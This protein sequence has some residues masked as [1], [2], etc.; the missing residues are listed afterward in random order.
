MVTGSKKAVS[1]DIQNRELLHSDAKKSASM[2]L[3]E[4]GCSVLTRLHADQR[5]IALKHYEL[6]AGKNPVL[7]AKKLREIIEDCAWLKAPETEVNFSINHT[8]KVLVPNA[9]YIP[10]KAREA[11]SFHTHFLPSDLVLTTD[12]PT[13]EAQLV[14]SVSH[15]LQEAIENELGRKVNIG[16]AFSTLLS[17]LVNAEKHSTESTLFAHIH[18]RY[19]D[20]IHLKK[21]KVHLANTFHIHSA[22]DYLYYL[23]FAMEQEGLNPET[24]KLVLLGDVYK[25]S[26]IYELSY[27]YVRHID[28]WKAKRLGNETFEFQELAAHLYFTTFRL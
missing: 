5:A 19:V 17:E 12:M 13:C 18:D 22:E 11:L 8:G 20:L 21:G 1:V 26:R 27:Q 15:Y 28:F 2:L 10:E 24:V 6:D 16:H 7:L 23:L 25:E 4:G 14:F 9:F 3:S